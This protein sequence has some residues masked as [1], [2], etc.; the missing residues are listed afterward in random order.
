MATSATPPTGAKSMSTPS[1]KRSFDV[2]SGCIDAAQRV[3][4]YG[5]GGIG[6]TELCANLKGIG[7]DPLFIDIENGSSKVDVTRIR[8]SPTTFEEMRDA[9]HSKSIIN[10]YDA[11]V[12]ESLT[13]TE[14]FGSQWVVGNVPHI[15]GHTIRMIE[16]YGWGTGFMHIYEVFLKILGDLDA[17]VRSGKHVICTAHDCT[18]SVPN[19]GGEDWIRYEPRL[20]SPKGGKA[21][22]RLRVKE[23][24]DH[25]LFI[26][27]DLSV[28]KQGKATGAG[29]RTIY[30]VELPTHLAKSRKLSDEIVYER[31]S[32]ELWKQLFSKG[33]K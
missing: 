23:W 21:S 30:P 32:S 15:K 31:G 33:S 1:T 2:S 8:P 25:L 9:L 13:R 6:K 20:Q 5:S 11:V 18:A 12:I 22:V 19:P 7:L 4:I 16:D 28:D 24:C 26:G 17:I 27:Y 10:N 3:V 29:T 14:E